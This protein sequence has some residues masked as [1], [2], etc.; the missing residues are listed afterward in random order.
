M[1]SSL[2]GI[3]EALVPVRRRIEAAWHEMDRPT[4]PTDD[5]AEPDDDDED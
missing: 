5:D 2:E 3:V 4:L 1:R